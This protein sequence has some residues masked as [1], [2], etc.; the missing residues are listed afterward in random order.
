MYGREEVIC[1]GGDV[2]VVDSGDRS[3]CVGNGRVCVIRDGGCSGCVVGFG[4]DPL[5]DIRGARGVSIARFGI[6]VLRH[7]AMRN[8]DTWSDRM[9]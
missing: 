9:N 8:I 7:D 5:R 2:G 4:W 6:G 1:I 3:S